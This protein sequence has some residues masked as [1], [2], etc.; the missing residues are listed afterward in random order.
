MS[1]RSLAVALLTCVATVLAV[2]AARAA[3]GDWRSPVYF[4]P[5]EHSPQNITDAM[6]ASGERNFLLAFVLD[7]GGCTPAWG[8]TQP[9]SA[10]TQVASTISAIRAAGGD[11]GV[12]FGGF[13][14]TE[15]G[16]SCGGADALAA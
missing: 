14:G 15:L 2:P 1:L 9:V 16:Q 11:A 3:G 8:G 4:M 7:S 13:N 5:L 12:S 10:D 6:T